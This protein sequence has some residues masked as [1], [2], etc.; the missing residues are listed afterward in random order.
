MADGSTSKRNVLHA[1]SFGARVA[2]EEREGLADYFVETDQWQ[3]VVSGQADVVFGPKGAGK[4]AIY[5]S[6]MNREAEMSARGII[7]VTA[8]KPRGSTVFQG[9]VA[10]PPTAEIEF[11]S[12]WKLYMLSLLGSVISDYGLVGDDATRLKHA[13]FQEGLLD[14]TDVSL[15]TRFR[16]VWDWIKAAVPRMVPEGE[17]KLDPVTST[18]VGISFKISLQEPSVQEEQRV[19]FHWM[20]C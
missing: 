6:L 8:E 20:I 3:K 19:L 15:A 1:L 4:S 5:T 7:L 10:D 13:L 11:V 18:P 9:L 16:S 17:L 12:I 14:K 2:E